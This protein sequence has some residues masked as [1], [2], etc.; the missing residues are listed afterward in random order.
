[1]TIDISEFRFCELQ[2][3]SFGDTW[4]RHCNLASCVSKE[5][6]KD[7]IEAEDELTSSAGYFSLARM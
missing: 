3:F 6:R 4:I 2:D 1:M 7:T 5:G